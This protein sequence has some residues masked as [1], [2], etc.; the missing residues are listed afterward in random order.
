M[1]WRDPWAKEGEKGHQGLVGNLDH[2]DLGRKETEVGD[3]PVL[4][5]VHKEM[6]H[7]G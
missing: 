3:C 2:L 4:S 6:G 1:A 7:G 5:P